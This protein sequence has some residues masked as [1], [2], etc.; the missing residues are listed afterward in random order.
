MKDGLTRTDR[1]A[2]AV[3]DEEGIL[4]IKAHRVEAPDIPDLKPRNRAERRAAK[5]GKKRCPDSR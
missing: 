2:A 1:M 4:R 5:K 3:L